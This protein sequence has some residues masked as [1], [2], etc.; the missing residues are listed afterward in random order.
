M[1]DEWS[2]LAYFLAEMIEK[3]AN[4]INHDDLPLPRP[5]ESKIKFLKHSN[6]VDKEDVA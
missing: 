1:V 6:S 5:D 3:Y 2:G 4:E